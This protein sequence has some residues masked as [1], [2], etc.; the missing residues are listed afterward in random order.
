MNAGKKR[1][2]ILLGTLITASLL[3][4]VIICTAAVGR[5]L[6]D[7]RMPEISAA[8]DSPAVDTPKNEISPSRDDMQGSLSADTKETEAETSATPDET[9]EITPS[10]IKAKTP[11]TTNGDKTEE[12]PGNDD[13]LPDDESPETELTHNKSGTAAST[14]SL[15]DENN[16]GYDP[17]DAETS[18]GT[19]ESDNKTE[20]SG[21]IVEEPLNGDYRPWAEAIELPDD[22]N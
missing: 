9:K 15:T 3:I 5:T 8:T 19:V 1:I 21:G 6:A 22:D 2:I 12:N 14:E 10:Y 17:S 18:S 11:V 16:E 4:I 7:N 20:E 13:A